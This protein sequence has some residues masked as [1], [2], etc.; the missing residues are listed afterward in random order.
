MVHALSGVLSAVLGTVSVRQVRHWNVPA[1]ES[2][3]ANKYS[4]KCLDRI[5]IPT[6][7]RTNI[8]SRINT[9]TKSFFNV[10]PDYMVCSRGFGFSDDL[11]PV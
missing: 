10:D 5:S 1:A 8:L 7:R 4:L 3:I 2:T 11:Y 6:R 9:N